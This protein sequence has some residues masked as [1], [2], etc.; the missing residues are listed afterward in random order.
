M[1]PFESQLDQTKTIHVRESL[2][3]VTVIEITVI[4]HLHSLISSLPNQT[5]LFHVLGAVAT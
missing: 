5:I 1:G 3:V 2:R 4:I